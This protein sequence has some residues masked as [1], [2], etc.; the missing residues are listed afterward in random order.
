MAAGVRRLLLCAA[1]ALT[2]SAS[3]VAAEGASV[4]D[5]PAPKV[6]SSEPAAAPAPAAA[7]QAGHARRR[8]KAEAR[9]EARNKAR[10][11]RAAR[12]ERRR[13]GAT[14]QAKV[15]TEAEDAQPGDG[16]TPLTVKT[17]GGQGD[18]L[19]AQLTLLD[20][21]R[22]EKRMKPVFAAPAS[23]KDRPAPALPS[24]KAS[25]DESADEPEIPAPN[26]PK[27]ADAP[28]TKAEA[29]YLVKQ[30]PRVMI[31]CFPSNLRQVLARMS[32][33]F[34][35]PVIVTSGFRTGGRRHSQHRYCKA[36]DIQI[37]GVRPSQIVGY[38]QLQDE[39]GGIGT[40]RHTRSVHV[41][42]REQKIS[43]YGN[44]GRG[45]FRLAKNQFGG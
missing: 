21:A 4:R 15:S 22:K 33:H 23:L 9:A 18:A 8:G 42:V 29:A 34:G 20:M 43:W 16:L 25:V 13:G 36:A 28:T 3:P 32:K 37:A 31:H 30:T 11:E 7:P 12:A 27:A 5:N 35:S 26:A 44:R 2:S 10:A 40:Y 41:D 1:V 14:K 39:V 45:H 19:A 6:E 17:V 24:D 38:A